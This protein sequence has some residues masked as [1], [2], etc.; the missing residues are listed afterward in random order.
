MVFYLTAQFAALGNT[1]VSLSQG[2]VPA[3][4]GQIILAIV[5]LLYET[6]GG[7]KGVAITDVLQGCLLLVGTLATCAVLGAKMRAHTH[8][9]T[10]MRAHTH[11]HTHTHT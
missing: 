2:A 7:L 8:L 3:I 9:F 1:I 5:M 6:F 4:V 10:H 11:T